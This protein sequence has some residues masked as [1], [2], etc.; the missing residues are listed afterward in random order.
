MTSKRREMYWAIF[1]FTLV[2][3]E[4]ILPNHWC[5][6]VEGKNG[7]SRS[8]SPT[9][10]RSELKAARVAGTRRENDGEDLMRQLFFKLLADF[11]DEHT[12]RTPGSPAG[13]SSWEAKDLNRFE[14]LHNGE[15]TEVQVPLR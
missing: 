11:S 4:G 12:V 5:R 8:S 9:G 3:P 6:W 13:N 7:D 2:F 14:L 10:L 1:T 15:E